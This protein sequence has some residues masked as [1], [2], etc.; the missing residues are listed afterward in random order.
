MAV[1]RVRTIRDT[2]LAQL[3]DTVRVKE[4]IA[5]T[6][7]ALHACSEL[8]DNCAAFRAF[9]IQ[10]FAADSQRFVAFRASVPKPSRCQFKCG[11]VVTAASMLALFHFTR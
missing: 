11:V 3:T 10:K 9:A 8:V 1:D 7:T 2:V 5:R 4:Y 6:D